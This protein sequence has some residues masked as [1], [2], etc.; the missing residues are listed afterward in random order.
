MQK[1]KEISL[2]CEISRLIRAAQRAGQLG[3]ATLECVK[4]HDGFMA[5]HNAKM[6]HYWAREVVSHRE[7][8]LELSK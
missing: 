6:S 4:K 8:I 2:N 7:K 5:Y 3:D 1:W